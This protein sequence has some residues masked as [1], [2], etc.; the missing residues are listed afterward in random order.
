M[1]RMRFLALMLM[2]A[3]AQAA[4]Q[5]PHLEL[6]FLIGDENQSIALRCGIDSMATD[7]L[8]LQLGEYPIPGHPPDGFHAAWEITTDDITDLSYADFRP[9]PDTSTEHFAVE[10]SLNVTPK[11]S[12]R[13][14]L[15][16]FAWD[17]PLP[18]GIDSVVVTDRLGG[19]LARIAFG[20]QRTDTLRGTTAELERFTVRVHYTPARASSV[21]VPAEHAL[22]RLIGDELS[23]P[24]PLAPSV[25]AFYAV[26][27]RAVTLPCSYDGASVRCNIR[28]LNNGWYVL[29]IVQCNGTEVHTPILVVGNSTFLPN[30]R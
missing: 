30:R 10:Y 21:E 16:I 5:Q 27:G 3:V 1:M 17:Y 29:R 13:G 26:D 24:L 19:V 25:V 20:P 12:G 8:D 28:G 9:Y 23:L 6:P 18:R 11:F 15:L 22:P 2:V 4:Q 14:D 7:G